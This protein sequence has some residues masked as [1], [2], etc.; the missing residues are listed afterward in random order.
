MTPSSG[1]PWPSLGAWSGK[2]VPSQASG[3]TEPGGPR[4]GV[5]PSDQEARDAL[6][7]LASAGGERWAELP[8]GAPPELKAIER[9][10]AQGLTELCL[11]V[12]NLN[13]FLF[14]D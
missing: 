9:S 4:W 12:F 6:E 3:W 5:R 14:V 2:G 7:T 1:R 13:E 11:A 8:E 10:Q